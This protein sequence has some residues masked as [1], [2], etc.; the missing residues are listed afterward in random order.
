MSIV[1]QITVFEVESLKKENASFFLLDVREPW[2]YEVSHLG[3]V[4]IP[5]GT[6]PDHLA[7]IPQDVPVVV[8]CRS[9]ARSERAA[10]FLLENGFKDVK[11]MTGG[12]RQWALA[13]QPGMRVA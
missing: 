12:I 11:N 10:A 9:G 13:I 5:L 1:P 3:G 4:S 7:E 8:M 6:L 2:E